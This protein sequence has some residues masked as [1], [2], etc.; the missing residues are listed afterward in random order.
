VR[1]VIELENNVGFLSVHAF[2]N[3]SVMFD[4]C[5]YGGK[6]VS[7][8]CFCLT[9]K[10]TNELYESLRVVLLEWEHAKAK[11]DPVLTNLPDHVDPKFSEVLKEVFDFGGKP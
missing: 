3:G 10:D 6:P 4:V 5:S 1:E 7:S 9:P 8:V 11:S 2:E